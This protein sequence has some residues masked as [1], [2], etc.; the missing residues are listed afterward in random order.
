[1]GWKKPA[2][3]SLVSERVKKA[4]GDQ[5]CF[6]MASKNQRF[7]ALFQRGFKEDQRWSICPR[8]GFKKPALIIAVSEGFEESTL[9]SAVL[10]TVKKTNSDHRCFKLFFKKPVLVSVVSEWF[11]EKPAPINGASERDEKTS[12]DQ[13]RFRVE[14]KK[15]TVISVVSWW[16]RK[17]TADQRC[18]EMGSKTSAFQ[19][20]FR[21]GLRKSTL[22]SVVSES[23]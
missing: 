2:L 6:G 10:E 18:F 16:V 14:S 8:M 22:I 7:S 11:Q 17:T 21:M 20:C 9:I 19:R 3:I 1:M 5:C 12:A 4:N 13:S 15:P 23:F